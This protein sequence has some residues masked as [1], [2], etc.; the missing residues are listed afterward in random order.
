MK[1]CEP[2]K[3]EKSSGPNVSKPQPSTRPSITS[4]RWVCCSCTFD[5]ANWRILVV[6]IV[7][8]QIA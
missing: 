5:E 2:K 1:K 8:R 4:W 3:R 6:G 7:Y